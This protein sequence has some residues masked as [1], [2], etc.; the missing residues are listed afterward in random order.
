M[1]SLPLGPILAI[2]SMPKNPCLVFRTLFNIYGEAFFAENKTWFLLSKGYSFKIV[3]EILCSCVFE[4]S[5]KRD[6]RIFSNKNGQVRKIMGLF[7]VPI[8]FSNLYRE[9][10]NKMLLLLVPPE[11][12][13]AWA[14]RSKFFEVLQVVGKSISYFK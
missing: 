11:F 8:N 10:S 6:V 12:T 13:S 14:C 3:R 9:N 5:Q 4:I 1:G 2:R 7:R